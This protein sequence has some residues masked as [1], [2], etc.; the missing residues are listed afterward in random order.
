NFKSTG[1]VSEN[2]KLLKDIQRRWT[3]I[4]HV[5]FKKKDILQNKFREDIGKLFDQLN[6][7]EDKRILLKFK[8]KMSTFSETS[9]GQSKMRMER[10]KYMSKLK[11]LENDLVLLENNI[12]FFTISKNAKALNEDVNKKIEDTRQKI[13][14]LKEKIRVIDEMED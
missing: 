13:E 5:P 12:G 10:E 3:E 6:I 11:Q 2:L 14:S 7:N 9:R 8:T 1:D 4:G